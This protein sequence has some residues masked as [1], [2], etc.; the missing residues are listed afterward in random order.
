MKNRLEHKTLAYAI[1]IA[2]IFAASS[3]AIDSVKLTGYAT[4]NND[5]LYDMQV[6]EANFGHFELNGNSYFYEVK[7]INSDSNGNKM[8]V[9]LE[10]NG[11]PVQLVLRQDKEQTVFGLNILVSEIRI[12]SLNEYGKNE[13]RLT[14]Y[15]PLLS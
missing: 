6:K 8:V 5:F 10:E 13:A 11:R 1:V 12:N 7:L 4:Y 9:M 15:K 2:A 14:V 3:F